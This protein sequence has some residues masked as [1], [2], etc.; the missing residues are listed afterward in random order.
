MNN[1]ILCTECKTP[2]EQ[3]GR[4]TYYCPVCNTCPECDC[5]DADGF[6]HYAGCS[7]A[8]IEEDD[9]SLLLTDRELDELYGIN[10]EKEA[11]EEPTALTQLASYDQHLIDQERY[12]L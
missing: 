2:L 7:A 4:N 10:E 9:F 1:P 3:T 5:P 8:A 12:A 11:P 6:Q